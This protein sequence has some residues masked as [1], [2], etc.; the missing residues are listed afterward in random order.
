MDSLAATKVDEL[1]DVTEDL[2][3]TTRVARQ[4]LKEA[5]KEATQR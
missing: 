5:K 2:D 3:P 4:G 1:I